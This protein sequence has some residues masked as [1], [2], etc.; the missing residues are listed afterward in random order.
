MDPFT[1][2]DW[3]DIK[4]PGA[5][6]VRNVGKTLVTRTAGTKVCIVSS[7]HYVVAAPGVVIAPVPLQC[8]CP[9]MVSSSDPDML[10]TYLQ[11]A[12]DGLKGRVFECNLADLQNVRRFAC[13]LDLLLL[14]KQQLRHQTH[15]LVCRWLCG[16]VQTSRQIVCWLGA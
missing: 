15:R 4:A 1:K 6:T 2:K 9:I 7:Y 13:K 12:A 5:F 10:C 16:R 3:Y 8:V 11:I 14:S